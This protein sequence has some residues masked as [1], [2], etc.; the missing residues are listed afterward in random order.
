MKASVLNR[1]LEIGIYASHHK[2]LRKY[3]AAINTESL[4]SADDDPSLFCP[5]LPS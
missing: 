3:E 1:F 4:E 2:G 5:P